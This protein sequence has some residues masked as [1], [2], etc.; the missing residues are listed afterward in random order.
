MDARDRLPDDIGTL[1]AIIAEHGSTL[2]EREREA[3]IHQAIIA[4]QRETIDQQHRRIEQ[5]DHRLGELLR[6]LYGRRSEKI[7]P[8][9]L[10]LFG[11]AIDAPADAPAEASSADEPEQPPVRRRRRKVRDIPD[12][13]PVQQVIHDIPEDERPCPQCGE[14]REDIGQE[15]SRQLE[16]VPASLHVIEHH[17]VIC[18]CPRCE[19]NV[20]VPPPAIKPIEK[21]LPGPGLLAHIIT[22]KYGDHLPLHR[23]EHILERHGIRIP[24][25]TQCNWMA[26][27]A[28]L[29]SPLVEYMR[30]QVLQSRIIQTDDT[31]VPVLDPQLHRTRTGRL[32]VYRGDVDHPYVLFDFTPDRC[33][34]GPDAVLG[35]YRGYI[36]ADAWPGYDHLFTKEDG[37]TE[38]GC[39]S[40]ARR[41]FYEARTSDSARA[42]DILGRIRRLY[43]IEKQAGDMT[44][45][46][47][48][49]LRQMEAVPILDGIHQWLV[50]EQ[51]RVLPKSPMGE[52]ISYAL[53]HFPALRRYVEAGYIP[54][55]NNGSENELRHVV[56]GRKNYLFV[57]SNAGGLTAAI[58]YSLIA[59]C[60]RHRIDPFAYLRDTLLAVHT[61]PANQIA[62]LLPDAWRARQ[63]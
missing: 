60:R 10:L 2:A 30:H 40:H 15:I 51:P 3:A 47:R 28:R 41:K 45:A 13:L 20:T 34:D 19:G 5:Y 31:T 17:R 59:T 11:Q 49:A 44:D 12:D 1:K 29:L 36:Q 46:D 55:D 39:W 8:A 24:R 25:S 58:L 53:N 6:K 9:Q 23:Q 57:G 48:A 27:G 7:D 16:Y 22:S 4:E 32:W 21:G 35:N 50:S 61:T 52:A 54:I 62:T 56:L 42:H 38:I 43:A 14:R 63:P 37:P 26:A 33:R 18:A